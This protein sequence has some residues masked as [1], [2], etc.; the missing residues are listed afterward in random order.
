MSIRTIALQI[1]RLYEI[2]VQTLSFHKAHH[3]RA[4][5]PARSKIFVILHNESLNST[6]LQT[7]LTTNVEKQTF[8][9]YIGFFL[10]YTLILCIYIEMLL[11]DV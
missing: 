10:R 3:P 6:K 1:F 4:G 2:Q 8:I 7:K 11:F 9:E 5:W